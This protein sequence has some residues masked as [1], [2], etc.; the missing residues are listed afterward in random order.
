MVNHT[1]TGMVTGRSGGRESPELFT[2]LLCYM[3]MK[4]NSIPWSWYPV[5]VMG[6]LFYKYKRDDMLVSLLGLS[7]MGNGT[8]SP[9]FVNCSQA[10]GCSNGSCICPVSL[11]QKRPRTLIYIFI[12]LYPKRHNST[13]LWLGCFQDLILSVSSEDVLLLSD[14]ATWAFSSSLSPS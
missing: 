13:I 1:A 10:S 9:C 6:T 5:Q 8:S 2:E 4:S 11:S 3:K 12:L 14:K 7:T